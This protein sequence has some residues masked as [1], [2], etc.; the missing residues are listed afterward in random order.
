MR[1]LHVLWRRAWLVLASGAMTLCAASP[2]TQSPPDRWSMFRG[3]LE[4]TGQAG[5]KL[6]AKLELLWTFKTEDAFEATGAITD[7]TVYVP[8]MDGRFYALRLSD[9]KQLWKFV[10]EDQDGAKSSPCVADD[11]VCYGDE[12]G[13]F[14]ALDRQSGRLRWKVTSDA[15]IIS[16]PSYINGKVLFGS[17]DGFLYCLDAKTGKEVWKSETD[18]P[19]HCSPSLAGKAV[20]VAGCD[21]VLRLIGIADGKQ[22]RALEIG[23]NIAST[24]AVVGNRLF[25]GTMGCQVLGINTDTMERLWEYEHARRQFPYYGSAAVSDDLVVIGGRDKMV[26]ALDQATGKERWSLQTK[27]RVEGSPVVVGDRIFVGSSDGT[28]YGI[29]LASGRKCWEFVTGA[30]LVASPAVAADRLVIGDQEGNLYCFGA[31][32]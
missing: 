17:Y 19:V 12:F 13:T 24:P 14:R 6:P 5:S 3:T 30:P 20:A 23:G 28:L 21:G 29:D 10:N 32:E 31:K 25:L 2:P 7:G 16:S 15:E 9:G 8:T 11:L 1:Q 26:H 22:V 27:G 18:G 4:M